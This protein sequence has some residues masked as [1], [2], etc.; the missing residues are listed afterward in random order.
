[1]GLLNLSSFGLAVGAVGQALF[2]GYL[3]SNFPS[4]IGFLGVLVPWFVIYTIT[5]CRCAPC[6][7]RPF[8]LI[9]IF[10]MSWYTAAALL[11]EVLCLIIRPI[12]HG[13]YS[14]IIPRLLM[15]LGSLSFIV[16]VRGCI[17]LRSLESQQPISS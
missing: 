9:L 16:F 2:F 10:A 3:F 17:S 12:P 5:F 15:Y 7:R 6:G 11:A 4:K 14:L 13:H 1:M 8:R